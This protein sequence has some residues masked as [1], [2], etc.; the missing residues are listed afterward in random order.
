MNHLC[1][2]VCRRRLVETESHWGWLDGSV[3][4]VPCWGSGANELSAG[5]WN[6]EHV[7]TV[8]ADHKPLP[9]APPHPS[10]WGS[11]L[12]EPDGTVVTTTTD[13]QRVWM[14][15]DRTKRQ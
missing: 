9:D 6:R 1:C 7:A 15:V 10:V 5:G 3:V 14:E 2:S 12:V 13:G 4:C 11:V 8:S